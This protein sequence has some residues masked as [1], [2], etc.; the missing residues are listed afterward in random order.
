VFKNQKTLKKEIF[1]EI[2]RKLIYNEI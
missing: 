2:I 1:Q